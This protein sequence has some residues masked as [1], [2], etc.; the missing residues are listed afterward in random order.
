MPAVIGKLLLV[1]GHNLLFQMFYGMPSRI[2]NRDGIAVQGVLGFVGALRRMIAMTAPTHAGVLFDSES[3]R[4]RE[5]IDPTYKANRP[6][7]RTVPEEDTPF[8]QLPAVYRA[9]DEMGIAHTEVTGGETDDAVAAYARRAAAGETELVIASMDSDFFQL[10][11]ARVFVL[12]YRGK[13]SVLC[14]E[15]YVRSRYGVT[16]AQYADFK[17]LTGDASD[18]IPGA[19][20][21]GSKTAA[22]LLWQFGSLDAVLAQ[23]QRIEKPSVRRTVEASADRLRKNRR[24]IRLDGEMEPPLPADA[25]RYAGDGRTTSEI[26]KQIGLLP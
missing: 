23:T 25:M 26:L 11:G 10:I 19:P 13:S 15:A 17:S 24:L 21:I 6:D 2:V 18:N 4:T 16:P 1:D 8:S 3:P 14:D 22:A 7:Y 5:E 12:R 9:L 20:G